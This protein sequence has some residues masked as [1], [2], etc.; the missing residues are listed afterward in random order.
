MRDI[1]ILFR[2]T[3]ALYN[4]NQPHFT[5][6]RSLIE[7]C[8]KLLRR[9][10]DYQNFGLYNGF[11]PVSYNV[12]LSGHS[13]S[14]PVRPDLFICDP[15]ELHMAQTRMISHLTKGPADWD[16]DTVRLATRVIYTSVM[17]FA[18]CIDLWKRSSRKTPGTFFEIYFAGL[19]PHVFPDAILTKHIPLRGISVRED[20]QQQDPEEGDNGGSSVATDLVIERP[21]LIRKI[22]VPLKITT[23][24]RIVQPFAHQRILDS[25][26]GAGRYHSF[27]TCISETQLD[28]K[29]KTVN[30]VCVPG[31]VKLFQRHL[32]Q[33]SGLYYCDV[34]QRYA[35]A[36][37]AACLPVKEIGEIFRDLTHHF[38]G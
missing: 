23:R 1:E 29:T 20:D 3:T 14:R 22:V 21:K 32:G 10:S 36:D 37:M 7:R 38:N 33:I 27:L 15:S 5:S 24:E 11:P 13:V 19:V 31:T 35:A 30:Q 26:F 4:R 8:L 12:F 6:C 9:S 28:L 25:A 18:C 2:E 17:S 34:P 16:K